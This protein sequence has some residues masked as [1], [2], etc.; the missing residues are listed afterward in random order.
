MN[1]GADDMKVESQEPESESSQ[2]LVGPELDILWRLFRVSFSIYLT[3]EKTWHHICE[4][5]MGV[6]HRGAY[7]RQE[8]SHI[9]KLKQNAKYIVGLH[10]AGLTNVCFSKPGAKLIEFKSM[11][12]GFQYENLAKK[13]KLVYNCISCKSSKF[14]GRDFKVVLFKLGLFTYMNRH[15][16]QSNRPPPNLAQG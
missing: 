12:T 7:L 10:G 5:S 3:A 9:E 8:A 16:H 11:T 6:K 2:T 14:A 13:N 4:N 1:L 15:H